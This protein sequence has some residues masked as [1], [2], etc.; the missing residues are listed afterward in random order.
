MGPDLTVDT[1]V[2]AV[3]TVAVLPLAMLPTL[4]LVVRRFGRLAPWPLLSAL[5]LVASASALAAF[6]VFPLPRPGQLACEGGTVEAGWQLIPLGSVAPILRDVGEAGLLGALTGFAFLQVA[7]NVALFVPYG[8][9]LHQATRWRAAAVVGAAA[10]TSLLIELVQGTAVL[11]LYPCPYRTFDVDDLLANTLGGA[12]GMLL[13]RAVARRPFA[14]PAA[15]PDLAPPSVLRRALALAV[16][17]LAVTTASFAA[18]VAIVLT[19]ADG[20]SLADA[21]ARIDHPALTIGVNL[22]AGAAVILAPSLLAREGTTP[23]QLLLNIAPVDVDDG[24][25]PRAGRLVSRWAVRWAPWAIIPSLL[26]VMLVAELLS[27]LARRDRR[28][29]SDLTS[30][31]TMRTRPALAAARAASSRHDAAGD[32]S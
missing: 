17:L 3:L 14:T 13:S 30:A 26:P 28:S 27:V 10:G 19:L 31:T 5:G 15:V 4:G 29:L 9:F 7:L 24:G 23:G 11:G 6:T 1:L 21:Q 18:T 20:G 8:F 2:T 12:L 25:R 32:P 16:D 22:A